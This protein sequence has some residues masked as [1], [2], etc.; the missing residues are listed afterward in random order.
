MD[1]SFNKSPKA[2]ISY[3][4]FGFTVLMWVSEKLHGLSTS[5]V[6]FIPIAALPALGVLNKKDIRGFSW[7]VL[8]LVGGGISLGL[9]MKDTGLASWLIGLV[10]WQSFGGIAVVVLFGLVGYA[11]SNLISNTVTATMIMPLAITVGAG[12]A[13]TSDFN[14]VASIVA[15]TV[16]VSCS[17]ILPISTPPNA[18][19]ISSGAI[20]TKDMAKVGV[21]V[22]MVGFAIAIICAVFV[23]P[24]LIS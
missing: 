2:I 6:A 3:L 24:F 22:G 19:A 10:S 5:M 23:W 12:L 14:L 9:S 4:I 11:L 21:V 18:I 17:M 7:E 1:C 8:W 16:I 15:I 20:E 13:A